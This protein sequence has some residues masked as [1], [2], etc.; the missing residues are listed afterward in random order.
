VELVL[1]MQS[2]REVTSEE[3]RA[4]MGADRWFVFIMFGFLVF[5]SFVSRPDEAFQ[6][7]VR[8]G[9]CRQ[10]V[11]SGKVAGIFQ[12]LF[13]CWTSDD[14]KPLDSSLWHSGN[15]GILRHRSLRK[16]IHRCLF[17]PRSGR[18]AA[19]GGDW[20]PTSVGELNRGAIDETIGAGKFHIG[21]DDK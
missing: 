6:S 3:F 7:R 16:P 1:R 9:H 20:I 12:F 19:K 2:T 8:S 21:G 15:G 4:V 5:C 13:R 17:K 18:P 11:L 14:L 10:D